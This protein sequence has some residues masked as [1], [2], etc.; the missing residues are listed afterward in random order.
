MKIEN[1]VCSLKLAK[2]LKELGMKQKSVWYFNSKSKKI[3]QK[4]QRKEYIDYIGEGSQEEEEIR[5]ID[6]IHIYTVAELGEV[7]R[8][9]DIDYWYSYPDFRLKLAEHD[10]SDARNEI[11]VE[12]RG[13]MYLYLL[14]NKLVELK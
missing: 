10:T 3:T 14:E 4:P 7:L 8:D 6:N 11:E 1:Q 5:Y 9:F 13:E 12:A 2:R